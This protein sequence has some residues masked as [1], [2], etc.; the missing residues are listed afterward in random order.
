MIFS[1]M[2]ELSSHDDLYFFQWKM[3]EQEIIYN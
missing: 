2:A 3:A 1:S